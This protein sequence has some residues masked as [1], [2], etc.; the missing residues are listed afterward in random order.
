M[1]A[2][3]GFASLLEYPGS[4]VR[5][6]LG[7]PLLR[8][9]LMGLAMGLTAIALV[10]SPYGKRS[11]GHFNPA[12]TVAFYRLGKVEPADAVWY[13][14]AQFAGGLAGVLLVA[15]V[16]GAGVLGHPAVRYVATVP[17]PYGDGP[18][19]L[20]EI[21]ISFVLMS[22]VLVVSNRERTAHLTPLCVGALV[23]TYITL[24]A[25]ISGMSM[26]PARTFGSAGIGR[27]WTGLW[28]YFTAP[29]VGMLLASAVYTTVGRARVGCAK[30]DHRGDSRCIFRCGYGRTPAS[31]PAR[32]A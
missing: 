2:A 16:V 29:L 32:P 4:P 5:Q 20:A 31:A 25:P 1:V 13:A 3:A 24:E 23:A 7:D 11:G 14:A 6:A 21:L 15:S 27:I 22:V 9:F 8:R 10:T 26:N 30:L 28:I 17:G 18:A 19:F 12:F